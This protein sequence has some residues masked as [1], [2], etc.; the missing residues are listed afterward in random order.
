MWRGAWLAGAAGRPYGNCRPGLSGPRLFEAS[1]GRGK[2]KRIILLTGLMGLSLVVTFAQA[3]PANGGASSGNVS[4][5]SA[6]PAGT[7]AGGTVDETNLTI[8]DTPQA[9]SPAASSTP[10]FG[11]WDLVRMVIILA[12]VV[13]AIYGLFYLIRRGSGQKKIAETELIK[14]LGSQG[15]PGNRWLHLVNVQKQV[16]LIGSSD[17][18][19]SLIAEITD[20]ESIDELRFQAQ[21][22]TPAKPKNFAELLGGFFGGGPAGSAAGGGAPLEFIKRQR[23]RLKKL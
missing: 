7:A 10:G 17:A 18:S 20:Q 23:D 5:P 12:L 3:A 9:N 22:E 8:P 1:L 4:A 15:L 6:A 19:V 21:T 13:A 14:L 11:V 16:F 2:L